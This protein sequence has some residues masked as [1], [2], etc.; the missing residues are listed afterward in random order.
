MTILITRIRGLAT[1]LIIATMNLQVGFQ[2]E[3]FGHMEGVESSEIQLADLRTYERGL[4][5]PV[6]T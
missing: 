4:G 5:G 3:A 1:P 6:G 2:V